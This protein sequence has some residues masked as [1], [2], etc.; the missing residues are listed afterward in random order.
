M[1][2]TKILLKRVITQAKSRPTYNLGCSSRVSF[3]KFNPMNLRRIS[4]TVVL[5]AAFMFLSC[6]QEDE[7]VI[8]QFEE[9]ALLKRVVSLPLGSSENGYVV[10][11]YEYDSAGRLIKIIAPQ[12]EASLPVFYKAYQYND[13]GQLSEISHFELGAS[14]YI[15]TISQ[16]FTYNAAGNLEKELVENHRSGNSEFFL[17]QYEDN[18]L[19]KKLDYD[20]AGSLQYYT[21]YDYNEAGLLARISE[22][23]KADV[24]LSSVVH[25]YAGG[26]LVKSVF[27]A[28]ENDEIAREET[29]IYDS[30]KNLVI[31]KSK[32]VG[33]WIS[34]VSYELRYEYF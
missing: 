31:L 21:V 3:K 11:E 10:E 16:Q 14:G 13:A 32:V 7:P 4:G 2:F 18:R 6:Q 9:G 30:N 1:I 20:E 23:G 33:S 34:S 28:G 22:F 17:S 8:P 26:L 5:L 25:S 29:R 27:Y 15:R 12:T 19:V 24:Y